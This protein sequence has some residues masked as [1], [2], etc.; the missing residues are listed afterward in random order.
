MFFRRHG[1]T[2][3]L[4]VELRNNSRQYIYLNGTIHTTPKLSEADSFLSYESA[5]EV[6]E[7]NQ[8]WFREYT[9]DYQILDV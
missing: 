3:V 1:K 2:Y 8:K 6:V 5:L 9:L 7:H 4:L